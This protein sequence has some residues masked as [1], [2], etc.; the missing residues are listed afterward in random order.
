M[1]NCPSELWFCGRVQHYHVSYYSP[2][3][4]K[5]NFAFSIRLFRNVGSLLLAYTSLK[6]WSLI[7][8]EGLRVVIHIIRE[9]PFRDLKNVI[10]SLLSSCLSGT[11]YKHELLISGCCLILFT[12][13]HTVN[14]LEPREPQTRVKD[15]PLSV[16]R[17]TAFWHLCLSLESYP[18]LSI[19]HSCL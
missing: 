4:K 12:W 5:R 3:K 18:S 19:F 2:L 8:H 10:K 15:L 16:G 1:G 17:T 14:H 9:F 13:E 6:C 7:I 11:S